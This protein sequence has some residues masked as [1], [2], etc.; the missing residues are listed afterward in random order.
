MNEE[1]LNGSIT[2]FLFHKLML[3][4]IKGS[5]ER[6]QNKQGFNNYKQQT[7]SSFSSWVQ[8]YSPLSVKQLVIHSTTTRSITRWIEEALTT[9]NHSDDNNNLIYTYKTPLLIL[10]GKSGCGKSTA[11]ELICNELKVDIKH[12]TEDS[13]ETS[14]AKNHSASNS[15]NYNNSDVLNYSSKVCISYRIIQY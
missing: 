4:L 8:K 5:K 3:Q 13:W 6:D 9:T 11:I 2:N 15:R 7:S 14:T 12:W 1:G 10:C